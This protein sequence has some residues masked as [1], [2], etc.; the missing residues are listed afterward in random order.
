MLAESIAEGRVGFAGEHT[1]STTIGCVDSAWETGEREAA[2][3]AQL[4]HKN[5]RTDKGIE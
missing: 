4:I 2:R 3:I 5:N 1:C